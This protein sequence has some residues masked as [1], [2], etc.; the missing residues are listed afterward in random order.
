MFER[1]V[2]LRDAPII[3]QVF[4]YF[5]VYGPHEEH[6]GTQASPYTQFCNQA[7]VNG[8]IKIFKGSK[9]YR[10]D[11]VHVDQIVEYHKK[12]FKVKESGTWNLGTGKTSSFYKVAK[13]I[14]DKHKVKIEYKEMPSVL[15]EN[16]QEFT[17]ASMSKV[18]S[19]LA[20][21]D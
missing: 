9:N 1:Y 18:E 4:R 20:R 15:K 16:Y 7:E 14:A 2:E 21:Y 6:K 19:T 5:N 10:R 8:T 11:F 13:E 17:Q 3:T 12:F